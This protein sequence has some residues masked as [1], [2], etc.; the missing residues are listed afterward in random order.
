M[1]GSTQAQQSAGETVQQ[2]RHVQ[3]KPGNPM[4]SSQPPLARL[5][6]SMLRC[7]MAAERVP[8]LAGEGKLAAKW[9]SSEG[10]WGLEA[11]LAGVAMRLAAKDV[12]APSPLS[13][14]AEAARG[15]PLDRLF[16]RLCDAGSDPEEEPSSA[17]MAL[18]CS[19]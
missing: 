17:A 4:Q 18:A 14:A 10:S 1:A 19:G 13:F 7:R 12:V 2:E 8:Q 6:V 9:A 16:R 15:V 3:V 5:Y 11:S